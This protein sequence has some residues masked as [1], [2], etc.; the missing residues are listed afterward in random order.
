MSQIGETPIL[1]IHPHV[2]ETG[3]NEPLINQDTFVLRNQRSQT[4]A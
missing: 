4:V 1:E 3:S 2:I